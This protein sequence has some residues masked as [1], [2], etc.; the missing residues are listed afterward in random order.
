[1]DQQNPQPAEQPQFQ[2]QILPPQE[3][4]GQQPSKPKKGATDD[5]RIWII[6]FLIIIIAVSLGFYFLSDSIF[7][8]L[9]VFSN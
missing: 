1:M 8:L 2:P 3:Q 4:P 5:W 6:I 9:K 7:F